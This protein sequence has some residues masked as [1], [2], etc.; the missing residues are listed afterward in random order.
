ML[1]AFAD[2]L[3]EASKQQEI[4]EGTKLMLKF[5]SIL[6]TLYL[7]LFQM[8]FMVILFQRY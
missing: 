6:M 8:P 7:F 1:F 3:F 2:S 5:M 4:S